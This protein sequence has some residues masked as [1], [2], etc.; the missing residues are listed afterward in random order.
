MS[1]STHKVTEIQWD[2]RF[3][4]VIYCYLIYSF[5]KTYHVF[6]LPQFLLAFGWK[7]H[8]LR[9]FNGLLMEKKRSIN[10]N[11]SLEILKSKIL[12]I[13]ISYWRKHVTSLII[14]AIYLEF[15]NKMKA[16]S[17][18]DRFGIKTKNRIFRI[19]KQKSHSQPFYR[20]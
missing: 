2:S 7:L 15:S 6:F 12:W 17:S 14:I 10:P 1:F 4:Y 20:V 11:R 16:K 5:S 8:K 13:D 18:N 3:Y 19:E 9:K